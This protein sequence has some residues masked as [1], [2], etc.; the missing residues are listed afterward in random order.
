MYKAVFKIDKMDCPCEENLIR[1]KLESID[2]ILN[3]EYD[4]TNRILTI[5]H[6]NDIKVIESAIAELSLGSTLL[7]NTETEYVKQENEDK[8]QRKAL[9]AAYYQIRYVAVQ[10]PHCN[11]C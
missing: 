9:W 11:S 8:K 5:I 3:Q 4:L 6:A 2:N 7:E 1:L 10:P